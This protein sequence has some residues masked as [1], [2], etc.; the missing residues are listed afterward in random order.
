[1]Y[2]I[3]SSDII[4]RENRNNKFIILLPCGIIINFYI[5]LTEMREIKKIFL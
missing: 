4:F 5:L 3:K 2:K 1:M